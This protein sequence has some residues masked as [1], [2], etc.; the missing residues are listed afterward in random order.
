MFLTL[1]PTVPGFRGALPQAPSWHCP[2][3]V[4]PML[5][6]V[7]LTACQKRPSHSRFAGAVK[8]G[9][10]WVTR[11]TFNDLSDRAPSEALARGA[12]PLRLYGSGSPPGRPG[13]PRGEGRPQ[14]VTEVRAWW[15]AGWTSLRGESAGPG[16]APIGGFPIESETMLA[17]EEGAALKKRA[18]TARGACRQRFGITG[19][20]AEV[21]TS[22]RS[23]RLCS[24][25]DARPIGPVAHPARSSYLP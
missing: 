19:L 24:A 17:V 7:R 5:L 25:C 8:K 18:A 2:L 9:R 16:A 22:G 21:H 12:R 1:F 4:S 14:R 11:T 13:R 20:Q 10:S 23:I 15:N 3:P 6:A